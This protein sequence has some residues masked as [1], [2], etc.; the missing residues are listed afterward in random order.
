MSQM[1]I[2]ILVLILV[3]ICFRVTSSKSSIENKDSKPPPVK[4]RK[5]FSPKERNMK[6]LSDSKIALTEQVLLG[7]DTF[8]MGQQVPSKV[9][10][11]K[12]EKTVTDGA[13]PKRKVKVKAFYLDKD[14]VSIS[15]FR[16]FVKETKYVTEA[17]QYGWSFVLEYFASIA[18]VE[19]SDSR[20]G[21]V[22]DATH[23]L[24]VEGADWRHPEGPDSFSTKGDR[25]ARE[26]PVTHV[27]LN[28]A[29]EYCAWAGLRLPSEAEWEFA[30]RGGLTNM[31]YPWG[32]ELLPGRMNI[33]EGAFPK[34]NTLEDGY[35]GVAPLD[36]YPPQT[37]TGLR[38][39][40][41]NVWEWVRGGTKKQSILRGGS[42][43]DSVLGDFNHI[44]LVSTR[45]TNGADSGANNV[46]FRCAKSVTPKSA[47]TGRARA[48]VRGE[49]EGDR[50]EL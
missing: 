49:E 11:N 31:S 15:Q 35:A 27:S 39:I 10:R 18:T 36:A 45:Q 28:D 3:S 2:V 26:Y 4:Q 34:E 37:A 47:K 46:G 25:A 1:Y 42:F 38:H 20:L 6:R 33:W 19:T 29:S 50:I 13:E 40:L 16:A 44:V 22:K 17:E 21:R 9:P 8:W 5:G 7:G 14:A 23:W 32:D 24:A 41:G 30:A 12:D 48:T 43:V